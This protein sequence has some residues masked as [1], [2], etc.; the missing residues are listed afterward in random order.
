MFGPIKLSWILVSLVFELFYHWFYAMQYKQIH[1]GTLVCPT[2][3]KEC[4]VFAHVANVTNAGLRYDTT[5]LFV[6]D[7]LVC[8]CPS[9]EDAKV[10]HTIALF[11][12]ENIVTAVT[13]Y[14]DFLERSS[15][16]RVSAKSE[17]DLRIGILRGV[18][19]HMVKP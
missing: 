5:P 17:K 12:G 11:E 19:D 10:C 3:G 2:S 1:C 18:R 7:T 8:A 4:D 6:V 13:R 14:L 9:T 15:N 16:H